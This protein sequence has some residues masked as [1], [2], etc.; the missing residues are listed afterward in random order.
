[1]SILRRSIL[2]IALLAP[3]AVLASTE[4]KSTVAS[5]TVET[6]GKRAG[7]VVAL[8]SGVSFD[9]APAAAGY[10]EILALATSAQVTSQE[11]TVRFA[12][13]G[14]KCS[15]KER[16]TDLV[17]FVF[18]SESTTTTTVPAPPGPSTPTR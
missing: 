9:M 7:Y 14:V 11:I 15:L 2:A 10:R 5:L 16:R 1:M 18:A 13:D 17:A 4:C 12:A 3:A 8:A 6:G